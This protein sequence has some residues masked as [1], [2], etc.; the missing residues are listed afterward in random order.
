LTERESR[1][2]DVVLNVD[3]LRIRSTITGEE[4]VK[5][6]SFSLRRRQTLGIVGES[7]SGKT[8]TCRAALG[9]LP[10]STQLS[11]GTVDINGRRT[12]EFTKQDWLDC[13]GN[14]P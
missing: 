12:A 7:G 13:R 9:I 10:E 4:L 11:G 8:L 3:D 5:G 1:L 6:V 2:P 14:V